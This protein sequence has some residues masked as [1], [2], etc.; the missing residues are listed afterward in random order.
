MLFYVNTSNFD[1]SST[2]FARTL[3]LKRFLSNFLKKW[4]KTLYGLVC[5]N[6][7]INPNLYAIKILSEV[8]KLEEMRG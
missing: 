1:L 6:I 5:T 7:P 4:V 3:R 2:L 8:V